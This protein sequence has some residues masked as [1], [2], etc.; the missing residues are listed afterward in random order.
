MD[1]PAADANVDVDLSDVRMGKCFET[2]A[3]R[4]VDPYAD[5]GIGTAAVLYDLRDGT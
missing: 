4:I 2:T 1:N 5:G 3:D